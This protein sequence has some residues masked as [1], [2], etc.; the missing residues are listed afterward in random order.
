MNHDEPRPIAALVA[1]MGLVVLIPF[2]WIEVSVWIGVV[3][4]IFSP[5]YVINNAL[6]GQFGDNPIEGIERIIRHR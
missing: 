3:L 2:L 1:V 5:I 6:G 4:L